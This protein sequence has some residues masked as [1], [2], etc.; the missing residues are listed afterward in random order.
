MFM[1]VE[2]QVLP[3]EMT[4]TGGTMITRGVRGQLQLG[5]VMITKR[6]EGVIRTT[7]KVPHLKVSHLKVSPLLCS[8]WGGEGR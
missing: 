7:D 2:G 3:G 4:I 1:G 5:V 8:L 6:L